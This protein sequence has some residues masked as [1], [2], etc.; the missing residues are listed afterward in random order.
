MSLWSIQKAFEDNQ[1]SLHAVPELHDV[2]WAFPRI[3]EDI[4]LK[5][6]KKRSCLNFGLDK[7]W[8]GNR[9]NVGA[10]ASMS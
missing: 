5:L 2:D 4:I 8:M 10:F 1:N 6:D 7:G 9:P 3:F